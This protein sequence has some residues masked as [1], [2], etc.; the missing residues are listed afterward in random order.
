MNWMKYFQSTLTRQQHKDSKM[1]YTDT[2]S[3]TTTA[4]ARF[5]GKPQFEGL[6]KNQILN[7]IALQD[8]QYRKAVKHLSETETSTAKYVLGV[9]ATTESYDKQ[10]NKLI[11]KAEL[12]LQNTAEQAV[13]NLYSKKSLA[14]SS[15]NLAPAILEK[16]KKASAS[17]AAEM[18]NNPSSAAVLAHLN[19]HGLV[20]DSTRD[21]I[22]RAHSPDAMA[23]LDRVDQDGNSLHKMKKEMQS[24]RNS[25]Y[26]P[27]IVSRTK[28]MERLRLAED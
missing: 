7:Q 24:F 4:R 20:P 18:V 6:V 10:F 19:K 1:V 3:P 25:N 22:N 15:E 5:M 2:E 16:F 27:E 12:D 21:A 28:D 14:Q 13:S 11:D 26:D 17:E 9:G 8:R 23:T